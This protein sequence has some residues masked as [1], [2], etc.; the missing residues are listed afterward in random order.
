[1]G[2]M[3]AGQR[4]GPPP[5]QGAQSFGG[6]APQGYTFQYSNCSGRRKA[7]LIGINY[8]GQ[9]GELR[10]CINDVSNVSRFLNERYGYK[11]EDMVILTDDQKDPRKIPTKQNMQQ[12]MEWLV[13]DAQPNDALF[14][15]YSGRHYNLRNAISGNKTNSNSR[16]RWT[17]GRLGR[18]R[19]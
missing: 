11:W 3:G 7:L 1:M 19:R 9:K 13:R 18:R 17:D 10:G 14:F 8:F 6:G 16:P 15:H 5:P 2:G 12:A 4:T